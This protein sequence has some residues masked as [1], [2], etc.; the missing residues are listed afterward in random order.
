MV[1]GGMIVIVC[2]SPF[3]VIGSCCG[4]QSLWLTMRMV[5]VFIN[6]LHHIYQCA[7]QTRSTNVLCTGSKSKSKWVSS[8]RGGSNDSSL[9]EY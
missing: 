4:V 8:Q 6:L 7:M 9:C 1:C 5:I 3:V 2:M